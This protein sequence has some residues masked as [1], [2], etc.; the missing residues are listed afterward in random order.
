MTRFVTALDHIPDEQVFTMAETAAI[1]R[2]SVK[3]LAWHRDK[4]DIRYILF[5]RRAYR[6]KGS[7]IKAFQ[8]LITQ[9]AAPC[10]SSKRRDRRTTSTTS[11]SNV[12]GISEARKRRQSERQSAKNAR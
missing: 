9:E 4:G 5:G 7:A 3:L 1:C 8:R 6:F 11:S 2:I 12:V 10:P